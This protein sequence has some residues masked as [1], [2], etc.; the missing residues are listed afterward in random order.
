MID[1]KNQCETFCTTKAFLARLELIC[2]SFSVHSLVSEV[3]ISEIWQC[4]CLRC[5]V[6]DSFCNQKGAL[7][8]D[9]T[10]QMKYNPKRRPFYNG[11][12][13]FSGSAS[14]GLREQHLLPPRDSLHFNNVKI[15][16]ASSFWE[17]FRRSSVPKTWPH[18]F[19][20]K[21]CFCILFLL[22]V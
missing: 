13:F 2:L 17:R 8:I 11:V 22:R 6:T 12:I 1:L 20:H 19:R 21:Q 16:S 9:C 15:S 4:S 5:S 14:F 10:R 18:F 7:Y 3:R